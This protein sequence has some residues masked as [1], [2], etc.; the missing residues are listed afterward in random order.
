MLD[1]GLPD[2]GVAGP[3]FRHGR[4]DPI[5]RVSEKEGGVIALLNL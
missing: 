4:D 5:T 2:D 1:G 3:V